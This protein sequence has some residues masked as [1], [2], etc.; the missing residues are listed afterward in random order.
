MRAT[1]WQST[2]EAGAIVR[3]ILRAAVFGLADIPLD[4]VDSGE[5]LLAVAARARRSSDRAILVVDCFYGEPGD[6]DRC[7]PIVTTTTLPIHIVHPREGAVRELEQVAG[8]S[9]V[10]LPATLPIEV[11]LDKVHAL[12][13][14]VATA[15][16]QGARPGLTDRERAVLRLV[17]ERYTD[18][19]I[20]QQLDVS[21]STVKAT[22]RRLK[23]TLGVDTRTAM[24]TVYRRWTPEVNEGHLSDRTR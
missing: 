12:R 20:A 8:R 24:R 19:Q 16:T 11:L 6:I 17:A 23:A 2:S 5:E 10:W 14:L 1:L 4:T 7:I 22:V 18:T 21:E 9:L 15:S 3:E 13:G